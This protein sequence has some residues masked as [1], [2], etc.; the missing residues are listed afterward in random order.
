LA[1]QT[2]PKGPSDGQPPAKPPMNVYS[3]SGGGPREPKK[4][5]PT[6]KRVLYWS[7]SVL[8]VLVLAIAGV[9]GWWIWSQYSNITNVDESVK[10]AR[11]ELAATDPRLPLAKQ[12]AIALVIGSD[13]RYTDGSAPPRSDTL[14]L[15]RIDPVHRLISLFSLPRDLYVD[16]PGLGMDKINAAFSQG[17]SGA[18][19]ALRTVESV[20]GIHPQ[21]L[22]VVNFRGF[23]SIVHDIH[24][25]YIP[26]DQNYQHSN[27]GLPT[28]ETYSEIH[29]DPGYQLLSGSN[30]LAFARYRHTDS[31]F[32]R[33]ARQQLFLHQFEKAAAARFHGISL[34]DLPSIVSVIGDITANTQITG[35]TAPSL[36]TFKEYA[37][38]LYSL[39]GRIVSVRLKDVQT[40][41]IGGA[42]VVTDS[43]SDISAAAYAFMHP[44]KIKQPGGQLPKVRKPHSRRF[45]PSK[46]PAKV[47]VTV[48]NGTKR[49]RLAATVSKGLAAWGYEVEGAGRNA[50]TSTFKRTWV[51]YRPGFSA[52]AHDLAK[53]VGR[54]VVLVPPSGF[55]RRAHLT[56][57]VSV[58]LGPDYSGR[59]AIRAPKPPPAPKLPADMTA[60]QDYLTYFRNAAHGAHLPGMYPTAIPN[61]STFQT[62]SYSQ[63]IRVYSIGAAGKGRNS[64]YAYFQWQG[65]PGAYWGIEETRFVDAPILQ[66]PSASR[67]LNGH[68]F[69]FYFNGAHIA[70]VAEIDNVHHVAYWVQNTLLNQ[71]SN[72]DMIALARSL[73]PTR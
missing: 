67:Q 3:G 31:D 17:K 46:D 10:K 22:A 62:F 48:L 69:N 39:H 11:P 9:V 41:M 60:T 16:I 54:G 52:A 35:R 47:T 44:W 15:V 26:V 37:A 49:P 33:N 13:H 55:A 61:G 27:A 73:T 24:G 1:I 34:S 59:L 5:R 63:P 71:L 53:I 50:P 6:W 68:R 32:Y 58:V 72:A 4:R 20:T 66:D 56:T 12:P 7:L 45:K 65:T 29:I 43:P 21:Y 14:M 19:L 2:P 25:V 70:M 51:F 28:S 57:G 8:G 38:L 42:S 18:S 64:L 23:Q 36:S 40:T 30:A